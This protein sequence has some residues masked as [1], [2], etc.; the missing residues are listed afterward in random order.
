MALSRTLNGLVVELP[1]GS[2]SGVVVDATKQGSNL[3]KVTIITNDGAVLIAQFR[4]NSSNVGEDI[5]YV[6]YYGYYPNEISKLL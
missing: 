5:T 6:D 2:G 1:D 3:Y 4:A